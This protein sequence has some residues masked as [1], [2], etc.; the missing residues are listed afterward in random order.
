MN[1]RIN[2]PF[3]KSYSIF[4]DEALRLIKDFLCIVA[5]GVAIA[6]IMVIVE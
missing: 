6:S 4:T 2:K 5:A 1:R 3:N